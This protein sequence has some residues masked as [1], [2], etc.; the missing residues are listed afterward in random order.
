MTRQAVNYL[1]AVAGQRAKLGHVHPHMLRHGCGYAL[2][3]RGT[4]FRV[5][6]DYLG[7][8]N[9]RHTAHH[10]RTSPAR[11]ERVWDRKS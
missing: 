6:Q 9:P 8:K 3:D 2:A 5:M 7:H 4:D 1:I 11:F 10:S